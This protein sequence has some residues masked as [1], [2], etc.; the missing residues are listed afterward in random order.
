MA[1]LHDRRFVIA[2]IASFVVG[3]VLIAAPALRIYAVNGFSPNQEL[4]LPLLAPIGPVPASFI[5]RGL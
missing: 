2:L 3:L 1:L 5:V 4:P